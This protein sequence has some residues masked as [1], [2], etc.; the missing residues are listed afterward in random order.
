MSKSITDKTLALAGVFQAAALVAQSAR[1]GMV[2]QATMET[3]IRSL[4]VRDP[5][6]TVDVYGDLSA[7]RPGLEAL[8]AQLGKDNSARDIDVLRY[9]FSLLQLERRMSKRR[10]LLNTVAEGLDQVERQLNHFHLTHDTIV[11]ALADIYLNTVSTLTPRIMVSGEHGHLQNPANANRV[12]A[13][14]LS[15]IRSAVLWS[16]CGGGRLQLLFRRNLFVA[17]A[18]RLLSQI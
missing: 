15:G 5:Q 13:L 6:A 1:S 11:A 2:D 9:A 16:Q 8:R 3:M 4:L 17:E 7:L 12:R 18:R 14:L 10:D